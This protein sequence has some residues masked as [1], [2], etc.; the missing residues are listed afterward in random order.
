MRYLGFALLAT[1]TACQKQP[2]PRLVDNAQEAGRY[3]ADAQNNEMR[4]QGS[5]LTN[6]Q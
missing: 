6:S 4:R 2:D 5:V 1:L 3:S